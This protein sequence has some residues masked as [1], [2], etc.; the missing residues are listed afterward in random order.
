MNNV[1][2]NLDRISEILSARKSEQLLFFKLV[3][4]IKYNDENG[5][6]IVIFDTDNRIRISHELNVEVTSLN[7]TLSRLVKRNLINR[8]T[9]GVYVIKN[10]LVRPV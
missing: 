1:I 4:L 10:D 8:K 2:I 6:N 3:E 9:N 5:D 7:A